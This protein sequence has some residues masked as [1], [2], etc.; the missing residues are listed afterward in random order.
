MVQAVKPSYGL[1]Q[2]CSSY[3]NYPSAS[4][5]S[6]HAQAFHRHGSVGCNRNK[7]LSQIIQPAR[8]RLYEFYTTLRRITDGYVAMFSIRGIGTMESSTSVDLS[9]SLQVFRCI[10]SYQ[11]TDVAYVQLYHM[12]VSSRIVQHQVVN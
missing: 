11:D 9:G 7:S 6:R 1:T 12:V 3:I 5:I 10:I 4:S 8:H 2:D